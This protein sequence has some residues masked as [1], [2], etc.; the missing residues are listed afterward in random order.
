M[1]ETS[2]Q[3]VLT[4]PLPPAHQQRMYWSRL[5]GSAR[6]LALAKLAQRSQKLVVIITAEMLSALNLV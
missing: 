3:S 4:P 6:A 5:Y 2:K 1:N